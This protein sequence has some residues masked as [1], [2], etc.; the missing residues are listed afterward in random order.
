VFSTRE[1]AIERA[2]AWVAETIRQLTGRM[3]GRL[4]TTELSP[5][6]ASS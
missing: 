5:T 6:A 1:D 4:G 3:P 2:E